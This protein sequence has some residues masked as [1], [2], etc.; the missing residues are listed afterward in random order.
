ME[1]ESV[2]ESTERSG[3]VEGLTKVFEMRSEAFASDPEDLGSRKLS[4]T[5]G[6]S[7]RPSLRH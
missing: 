6:S 5:R 1:G 7:S 4:L 3:G 2:V